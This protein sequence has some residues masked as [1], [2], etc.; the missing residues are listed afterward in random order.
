[1]S[2]CDYLGQDLDVPLAVSA[3]AICEGS[4][5][6]STRKRITE[7]RE[8]LWG[9]ALSKALETHPNQLAR[10]V[11]VWPQ[12]DK[13]STSWLLSL[14]GPNNGL[15]SS[16]FSEAVCSNL[17]LPSLTCR[18]KVGAADWQNYC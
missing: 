1:M 12:M 11:M 18:D 2:L 5:E 6:G 9:S 7:Q 16:V 14:P 8:M 17:C 3:D 15:T 10:P 13:L 4:I